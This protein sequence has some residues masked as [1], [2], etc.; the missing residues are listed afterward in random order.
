MLF[1]IEESDEYKE[2]RELI[3]R[4]DILR[5]NLAHGNSSERLDEVEMAITNVLDGFEQWLSTVSF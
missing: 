1:N 3:N 5:N 2:I 4:I